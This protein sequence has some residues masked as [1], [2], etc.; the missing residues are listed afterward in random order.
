M[1]KIFRKRVEITRG[2]F[3]EENSDDG[4]YDSALDDTRKQMYRL[5]FALAS[6]L[7]VTPKR[8]ANALF[9][10]KV[11]EYAAKFH[12]ELLNVEE[13]NLEKLEKELKKGS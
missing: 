8:L 5:V 2:D 3:I 12:Q 10:Q 1:W 7:K 6:A 13:K 11:D 9:T 4:F